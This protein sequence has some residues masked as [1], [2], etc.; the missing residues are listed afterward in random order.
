MTREVAA[1][2]FEP[3]FSTKPKTEGTGLGL[4]TVYGIVAEA[5]GNIGIYSELGFG[6][7]VKVHL[8]AT[9][10]STSPSPSMAPKA[11]REL[12]RGETILVVEDEESVRLVTERILVR[13][14]YKVMIAAR[15]GVALEAVARDDQPIDLML[16]DV[17]MPEMLGPQLVE[18]ATAIR[19]DLRVL[20]MSGYIH[21][22]VAQLGI[23]NPEELVIVEKPF[24]TDE[25]LSR[26]R[27]ALDAEHQ[28]TQARVR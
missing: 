22:A 17:V 11:A 1:R 21:P 10:S 28:P 8:P 7:T 13:A 16:T 20:Y 27:Q 25:L 26:V 12:G 23:E 2:A 15:G 6:T 5:G 19:P 3:F 14:G 18:R 9:A 4:A 24:T